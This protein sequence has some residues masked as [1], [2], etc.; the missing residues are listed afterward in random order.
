MQ[1]VNSVTE[2][3]HSSHRELIVPHSVTAEV[4]ADLMNENVLRP[5]ELAGHTDV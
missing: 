5:A 3:A 1:Y 4:V 2:V